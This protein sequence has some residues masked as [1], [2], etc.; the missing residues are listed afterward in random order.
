MVG[1]VVA[2]DEPDEIDPD[3]LEVLREQAEIAGT[4]PSAL[5]R[6]LLEGAKARRE[7]SSARGGEAGATYPDP[8][9]NT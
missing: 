5:L 1:D 8:E 2:P 9:R 4:T 6:L 3:V 7:P